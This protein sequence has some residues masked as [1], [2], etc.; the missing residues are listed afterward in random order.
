LH[1]LSVARWP[2][3]RP[4]FVISGRFEKAWPAK[5]GQPA[6]FLFSKNDFKIAIWSIL[7]SPYLVIWSILENFLVDWHFFIWQRCLQVHH[8]VRRTAS[9]NW[10]LAPTW[11]I[12]S[13]K[14]GASWLTSIPT[15]SRPKLDF[16]VYVK[17]LDHRREG[18]I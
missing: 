7:K 14:N 11:K 9:S 4:D 1:L 17:K 6:R 10:L 13:V 3:G 5:N 18:F 2:A 12:G 16:H 8:I 15:I